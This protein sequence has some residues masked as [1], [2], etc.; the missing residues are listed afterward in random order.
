[1][2]RLVM[3]SSVFLV[4]LSFS[5]SSLAQTATVT[6][7]LDE[8][9]PVLGTGTLFLLGVLLCLVGAVW[10]RRHPGN[11]LGKFVMSA[12]SVG[13]LTSVIS[14]GWLVGNAQAVTVLTSYLFSENPSPV[15]ITSF[16]AE[17]VNDSGRSAYLSQIDVAGCPGAVSISGTCQADTTVHDNGSCAI[18]SVCGVTIAVEG[19]A[20]DILVPTTCVAG[21]YYCQAQQVCESVTGEACV[22]QEY[23]C[24]TGVSGSWYPQSGEGS[25]DFNF[26]YDYDFGGGDTDYGNI[27][28]CDLTQMTLYGLAQ[29]H[30]YCGVGHWTRQ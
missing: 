7:S 20:G 16:P 8:A 29:T 14:G 4:L 26:A 10:L 28:A 15:V 12:I 27:C 5:A 11:V 18:D 1:M 2:R 30:T 3:S 17:L 23:D 9:I 24:Y 21:D 25:S 6:Y 22:H 13:L 19:E